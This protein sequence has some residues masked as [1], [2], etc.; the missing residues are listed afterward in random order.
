MKNFTKTNQII[1]FTIVFI[2][3]A[4]F[5]PFVIAQENIE[6]TTAEPSSKTETQE[7]ASDAEEATDLDEDES[8][9]MTEIYKSN[10][11][12]SELDE[13]NIDSPISGD[14]LSKDDLLGKNKES[15]S[16]LIKRVKEKKIIDDSNK[17]AFTIY[18][19]RILLLL[20][21]VLVIVIGYFARRV[22]RH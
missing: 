7:E 17:D 13:R 8:K 10:D 12:S 6:K 22:S 3:L 4:L 20:V 1:G 5:I 2:V 14:T 19:W 21:I 15:S 18:P 11:S 9:I 16:K